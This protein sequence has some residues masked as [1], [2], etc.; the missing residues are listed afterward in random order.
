[1][2]NAQLKEA[3]MGEILSRYDP[4][5][6]DFHARPAKPVAPNGARESLDL[7]LESHDQQRWIDDRIQS[8]SCRSMLGERTR[9]LS[10]R[11]GRVYSGSCS[12]ASA[13]CNRERAR[14]IGSQPQATDDVPLSQGIVR[15]IEK[16]ITMLRPPGL[17]SFDLYWEPCAGKLTEMPR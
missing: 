11:N 7:E 3:C 8:P 2:M 13:D 10:R 1:M 4:V 16:K 17:R 6:M 14:V 15:C 5:V 9:D 12:V